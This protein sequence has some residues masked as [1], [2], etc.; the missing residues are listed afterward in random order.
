MKITNN[1]RAVVLDG[2]RK[3][4]IKKGEFAEALGH[5]K[6]WSTRFFDGTTK[7]LDE[8]TADKIADLLDVSFVKVVRQGKPVSAIAARLAEEIERDEHLS[9]T[10][11]NLLNYIDDSRQPYMPWIP[12]EDLVAFGEE[13]VR[14]AHEDADK[15]GKVGRIGIVW[16]AQCIEKLNR[17]NSL[18]CNHTVTLRSCIAAG[19]MIYVEDINREICVDREYPPDHFALQVCGDSQDDGTDRA[20]PDGSTILVREMKPGDEVRSGQLYAVSDA[21]G[22][23]LKE[24]RDGK[25]VS[26]NPE[27]RE[28]EPLEG[29]QVQAEFVK[30][31]KTEGV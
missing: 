17:R 4:G 27:H 12:T 26:R 18:K 25:L 23:A 9:G 7:T 13:M 2:L 28:F 3:K 20:V 11:S 19:S 14:A 10:F 16:L 21:N 8:E 15:P 6:S 22:A 1:I 31:L 5:D 30:V 29:A 24:I